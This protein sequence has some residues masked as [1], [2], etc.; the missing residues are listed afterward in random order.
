MSWE[1]VRGHDPVVRAFERAVERG[2]LAHAYLFAGPPGVGKRLFALQL[3]KTLLCENPPAGRFDSCDRCPAC[4]QIAGDSHPDCYVA[5]LPPDKH[6]WPIEQMHELLHLFSLKSARGKGKVAIIDDADDLNEESA[7]AFLKTLEEPPPRSVILLIGTSP[8]LALPTILSRC[9]LVRFAPLPE[10]IVADLLRAQGIEDAALV[11]RL[12]RLSGGSPGLA[13]ALADPALWDFRRRMLQH[14]TASRID[15][16]ALAKAWSEFVE[17]VGKDTAAQRQRVT[18]VLRLLI[19]LLH[20]VLRVQ[21]DGT[22]RL[23]EPEE[24]R[25]LETLARR[26][27]VEKTLAVLERCLQADFQ[28]DRRVQLV[29]VLEALTDEVGEAAFSL[30]NCSWLATPPVL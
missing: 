21:L 25:I 27:D 9:Q 13:R 11:P 6:E 15:S 5:G 14:L 10:P 28:N 3:A 12:A 29:L 8:D 2:R 26:V 19:D 22:P 23:A 20:D 30:V 17:S 24:L 4:L 7:N 16:L 18:L 1:Q